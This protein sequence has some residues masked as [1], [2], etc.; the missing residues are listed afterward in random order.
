M[1]FA[2][3]Y[4]MAGQPIDFSASVDYS[5]TASAG[6]KQVPIQ[7]GTI[8]SVASTDGGIDTTT[9][10]PN[11][12]TAEVMFVVNTSSSTF[13]P[14]NLV[15]VDKNFAIAAAATTAN[16]GAPVYVCLSNFSAGNT[17]RQGG[18]VLVS[19]ICP[20]TTSVAATTGAVFLGTSKNVTPTAAAG[21][22]ILNAT[23]LVAASGSFT[24]SITT[25]NGSSFIKVARVN[26]LYPGIAVS[27]TGIPGSSVVSSIDASGTGFVLGSAVGTPANATATGTVTGTFTHTGY[28]V[29]QIQRPFVQG[30]IT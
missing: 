18:W 5:T 29:F 15:Q 6:A 27:G 17:T 21:K 23:C 3:V 12:G 24:R 11:W 20:I 26:G 16:T 22:Q 19:G 28:G 10:V 2:P 14:G 4:P 7:P 13:I 30:Q 1:R 9:N 25:Q 8:L